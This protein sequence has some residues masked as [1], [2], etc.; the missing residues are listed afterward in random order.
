MKKRILITLT[1]AV[2][3]GI[4]VPVAMARP[5]GDTTVDQTPANASSTVI[6]SEKLDG[7]GLQSQNAT[8]NTE[9]SPVMSEIAAG[10]SLPSGTETIVYT[11]S[12]SQF[13]WGD[14]GIGAG[15]VVASMLALLGGALVV[16]RRHVTFA[17]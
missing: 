13:D 17:H 16:R 7:L 3:F 8:T 5:A 6:V 10:F 15:V 11:S 12:G 9:A 2:A 1:I 4:A 14:A